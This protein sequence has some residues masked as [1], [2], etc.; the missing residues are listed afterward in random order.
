MIHS[1]YHN[2]T[3]VAGWGLLESPED[4]P[5]GILCRN[6]ACKVNEEQDTPNPRCEYQDKLTSPPMNLR[7]EMRWSSIN[8]STLRRR[9]QGYI[10]NS[11]RRMFDQ[12]DLRRSSVWDSLSKLDIDGD[13]HA[14]PLGVTSDTKLTSLLDQSRCENN[15]NEKFT[16]TAKFGFLNSPGSIKKSTKTPRRDAL[17]VHSPNSFSDDCS[18]HSLMS[19]EITATNAHDNLV[20]GTPASTMNGGVAGSVSL[21]SRQISNGGK[22]SNNKIRS[23]SYTSPASTMNDP[24]TGSRSLYRQQANNSVNKSNSKTR[25]SSY[26]SPA[27][28]LNGPVASSCSLYPQQANNCDNRNGRKT[29]AAVTHRQEAIR[30]GPLKPG[31]RPPCTV[32]STVQL[33]T[34]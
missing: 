6:N 24:V 27:H 20:K 14:R 12:R 15:K 5:L 32:R 31:S 21:H 29:K 30:K 28:T 34:T 19:T 10:L 13:S 9:Q 11:Q 17:V 23:R 33:I 18:L 3:A 25:S 1:T 26:T 16:D 22:K 2:T 7:A 4:E 8:I